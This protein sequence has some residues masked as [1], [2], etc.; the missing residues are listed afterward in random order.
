MGQINFARVDA[1]LIHGQVAT[2]WSNSV[3]INAIYVVDD[4]T[5]TDDFMKMIYTNLQNNYSFS[6][7]VLKVEEAIELWS[8]SQFDNDKV[9][10]L[11]KD[12]DHAYETRKAGVPFDVL[13]VGGSP[14]NENNKFVADSVALTEDEFNKLVE[15][16]EEDQVDV[17]FQTMPSATKKGIK[18][19][20]Y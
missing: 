11:F 17:Y 10:L 13:N 16:S 18:S 9:M 8:E 2:A 15:L 1:R 6:I 19:V 12:V 7:K 20:K 4:P 14:K 5:A 3:G